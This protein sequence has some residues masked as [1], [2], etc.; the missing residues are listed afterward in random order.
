M[1]VA[2][3][4]SYL[5]RTLELSRRASEIHPDSVRKVGRTPPFLNH[6]AFTDNAASAPSGKCLGTYA[7]CF[8]AVL[9]KL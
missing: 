9:F 2:L 7:E 3:P 1:F 8:P 4:H 5:H 6:T